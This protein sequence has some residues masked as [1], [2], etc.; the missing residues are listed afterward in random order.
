ME[1]PK[2]DWPAVTLRTCLIMLITPTLTGL[3]VMLQVEDWDGLTL[4]LITVI[5]RLPDEAYCVVKLETPA[6]LDGLPPGALHTY[7]DGLPAPDPVKV[8]FW[9]TL[10]MLALALQVSPTVIN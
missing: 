6:A 8:T 1:L 9:P 4:L 3:T 10:T 5:V 7:P 2:V